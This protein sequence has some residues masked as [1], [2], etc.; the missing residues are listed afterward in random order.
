MYK[1]STK[2]N[3]VGWD[4]KYAYTNLIN[5]RL[6][7]VPN[8]N[9]ITN[10]GCYN[11][12]THYF[13]NYPFANLEREEILEITHPSFILP[14]IEADLYSQVKEYNYSLNSL[15]QQNDI[16]YLKRSIND[17]ILK[18]NIEIKILDLPNNL[19]LSNKLCKL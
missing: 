11:N 17:I 8:Y 1:I 3:D 6:S 12:A 19:T 13:K 7:I 10:I 14:D 2:R 4:F 15:N 18:H 5:N 9:F 16:I